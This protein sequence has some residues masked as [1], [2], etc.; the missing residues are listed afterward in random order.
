[1]NNK[2]RKTLRENWLITM[3]EI[4]T[5]I[6]D[7]EQ[8]KEF[9]ASLKDTRH[10]DD[11]EDAAVNNKNNMFFSSMS[12]HPSET[13]PNGEAKINYCMISIATDEGLQH[14]LHNL[15]RFPSTANILLMF[16]MKLMFYKYFGNDKRTLYEQM[17]VSEELFTKDIMNEYFQQTHFAHVSHSEY[18]DEHQ[19][20]E[21]TS[22]RGMFGELLCTMLISTFASCFAKNTKRNV[23]VPGT[24]SLPP[25]M[26]KMISKK[27]QAKIFSDIDAAT[28]I[29]MLINKLDCDMMSDLEDFINE[30]SQQP[31]V[32]ATTDEQQIDLGGRFFLNP[33]SDPVEMADEIVSSPHNPNF[34]TT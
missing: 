34:R 28:K 33:D 17:R 30:R 11:E 19:R 15:L 4:A 22:Y 23:R 21:K 31:P 10:E 13:L 25:E 9:V 2:Q 14:M 18:N 6:R 5:H 7:N 8:L 12:E 16:C 26:Q 24:K 27:F 1:M 20:A 3:G 32:D 29:I